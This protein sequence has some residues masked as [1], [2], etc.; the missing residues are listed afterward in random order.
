MSQADMN[1]NIRETL[2]AG[3]DG[4][5]SGEQLR[6]LLRRLDHD[7]ALR[8][9]W[10]NYHLVGDGLRRQLPGVASSDFADRVMGVIAQTSSQPRRS[11]WL[12]W[13]AGGA[14]A[15]SVAAA[16][17]MIGQPGVDSDQAGS[18]ALRPVTASVP[19]S[20]PVQSEAPVVT[21]PPWL[22]GNAAGMLS[23]KASATFGAPFGTLQP[24]YAA[25]SSAYP[26]LRRYRT[27][28][29]RDG[30]YLLLLDPQQRQAMPDTSPQAA[31]SVQ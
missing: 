11:H 20:R 12:R 10:A 16:A 3:V 19:A 8:S 4:E 18:R 2:S 14:I 30:S 9:A 7:V 23:E 28:D 24:G 27:L 5:L 15:A 21:A 13:S 29:N 17:L 25:R 6:F 26:S 22:T 1:K 31:A